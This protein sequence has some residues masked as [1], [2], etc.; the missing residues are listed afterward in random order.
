MLGFGELRANQTTLQPSEKI[1][2]LGTVN[3]QPGRYTISKDNSPFVISDTDSGQ[4]AYAESSK[5]YVTRFWAGAAE[6]MT[7]WSL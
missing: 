3:E 5:M 1:F 7:L 2:V 4:V 6:L